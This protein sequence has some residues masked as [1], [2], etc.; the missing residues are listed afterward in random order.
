LK[1]IEPL[2]LQSMRV[3]RKFDCI[4][5]AAGLSSRMGSWKLMI[6]F[7]GRPLILQSVENAL[8]ACRRVILV[9]GHRGEELEDLFSDNSRVTCIR[10]HEYHRGMFSSIQTGTS[11]A[12][13]DWF[14]ITLGDMPYIPVQLFEQL[15]D[16]TAGTSGSAEK[17]II[18]PVYRGRPG[19]PVL[20]KR[21][22]SETIRGIDPAGSMRMVFE[23]H[24]LNTGRGV[25]NVPVD[26]RGCV[27]D[28]DT[29]DDLPGP[30]TGT[31]KE[32]KT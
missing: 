23:T 6:E 13:T 28:I 17:A 19:H 20:L 1:L 15:A 12:E 25:L 10:N 22:T 30:P 32:R 31:N 24:S 5:P 3:S 26:T 29:L 14:F 18:R 27:Y 7:S 21:E 8:D 9:T 2:H 4:I 16:R 11:I